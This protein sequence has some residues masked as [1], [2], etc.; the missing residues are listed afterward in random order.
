MKYP[1]NL[2]EIP[3]SPGCYIYKN[4]VGKIIYIGKAKNLK[5]R[6][7]SYFSKNHDSEKTKALVSHIAD[8]DFIITN[9]EV[10]ALLLEDSLIKKHKPKYNIDLKDSKSYAFIE[11]TN[12][13]YPRLITARSDIIKNKQNVGKLF[14]PFISGESRT[15]V[16]QI[17]N[18]TFKLRTCKTLPKKKCL[19]YEIGICSGPCVKA[20]SRKDYMVDIEKVSQV[21]EGRDKEL[22]KELKEKMK[23]SSKEMD[24][25]KAL[26]L[27]EQSKAVEYLR[28][29][30]NVERQKKHDEDIIN[31]KIK[32]EVVY[33]IVFNI[34]KGT[35]LNK[36]E[37][38]FDYKGN[39]LE[40]FLIQFYSE[41]DIPKDLILPGKVDDSVKEYLE[42]KKNAKVK[43]TIPQK[44]EL[45]DL[46][47]LVAKN[48]E[49]SFFGNFEKIKEL[50]K[51][52]N[53][54]T[55]PRVIECFDIS[56]LGGTEVVASMVQFRNGKP[57]KSNY[58]K[59]KIKSFQGNDDFRAMNEVVQR[60]YARL[61]KDNELFPDLIVIDGGLGQLNSSIKSL[62]EINVKI[63]IIS[64]A[65]KFEEVYIP[66]AEIPLRMPPK[67]K[68]RLLL[69]AIRDEAHRF[70]VK[71][72][73]ERR[74]KS[75]FD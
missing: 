33:L 69:Q 38:T 46:L 29:K 73:R 72:Q 49:L 75:Y 12:E 47:I 31:Y 17:I 55:L 71:F 64:L 43:I 66:G 52:I 56:H 39:F 60:R 57:D 54:P 24:Y 27:R 36:Q 11:L 35:L 8:F 51:Q 70:A 59:F 61:K 2:K 22:L 30:Q 16:I 48:I 23:A 19:R 28:E 45:K 18:K 20:I 9:S 14:G 74:S 21:L 25:E 4:S 50:Q 40:E 5:K 53:I 41:N 26:S 1:L 42:H 3:E 6:V 37:F 10:E 13:T 44:G 62:K 67:N 65:K 58:R 32:D 7:T 63:P 68:A 34:Y 15:Q